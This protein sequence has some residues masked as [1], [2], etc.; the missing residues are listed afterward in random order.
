MPLQK[1]EL[2]PGVNREGTTL[3]NE[4]GWFDCDKIRFR[5]GY[6]QKLGGWQLLS[7][8]T[9]R[10]LVTNLWNY[11]TLKGYDLLSVA[12]NSKYYIE[13]GG[14][15]YDIT[16]IRL[17]TTAGSVTFFATSGSNI[18]TV[19][20]A[21][22]GAGSGDFVT[23]FGAV[24]LGGNVTAVILNQEY[25][26]IYYSSNSFGIV[27]LVNANSLDTG[28]GGSSAYGEFQLNIGITDVL[29][30]VGW[31]AGLWGGYVNNQPAT[32]LNGAINSSVTTITLTSV[33][34]FP[35][36]AQQ[37]VLI[38]E[39][40]IQYAAIAGNTLTGCVRGYSG[41]HAVS[42]LTLAPVTLA[43]AFTSWGTSIG[44]SG[45]LLRLWSGDNFGEFL[46]FNPRNYGLY[47]WI[48]EYDNQG[49]ISTFFTRGVLL[50]PTSGPSNT[51]NGGITS[52][53]VTVVVVSTTG[54]PTVGMIRVDQELISYTAISSVAF[55]GCTR[56][57]GGTAPVPHIS[58][59]TVYGT[60]AYQTDVDCPSIMTQM[61][62]SDQSRFV[63]AFGCNDYGSTDQNRMLVR[64]S[65]QEDYKTW[66]PSIVNQA[67]SYLLSNGS[68][69]VS[70]IQ[71]RQE[72]FILTD[73]AAYS[74]QYIGPPYVWSFNILSYNISIIGPNTVSTAS[75]IVYWMGKDK[76][77]CYTGRVETLPCTLRQYVYGNINM[78]Q[79]NKFFSGTNEGYS[80]VWWFYCSADSDTIDKYV[81]YN[82]LD[83][84]WYYGTMARTA[85]L[86]SGVRDF[87]MA[88]TYAHTMVYHEVGT[89][90]QE[91]EGVTTA[92]DS[93]IQSSDF[94]IGDGHNYG[95]VWRII[96]DLTFDGS[97]TAAP[98]KPEVTLSVR[99]R[100][101]PGAPYGTADVPIV[102]S[103][104][105]YAEQKNYTV[106]EFTQIVYTRLRG[107]QMA[108]K[109]GSNTLGTQWQLGAPR[110]DIRP[111]GRR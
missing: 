12:T 33:V 61:L 110:I 29:S 92:I 98:D 40:L 93:Y 108:L 1:L 59:T 4:G 21:N 84:V 79:A 19:N 82:Y 24:S 42:H 23:F 52:I 95:F 70:A 22:H 39:E 107:R 54:F 80:E 67:G 85:W 66:T 75:D 3:S 7:P 38:G 63:I 97:T 44:T 69:I 100:Q 14:N 60:G 62:I 77:Y 57:I 68:G 65:D 48:P 31:G 47:M 74:M 91:V 86:D 81:I 10:G 27:L 17:T 43:N 96:P 41:T 25:E 99:P 76:F 49:V 53:D 50:S 72:I 35:S 9:Y 58:G 2:R 102:Q 64:W 5:S 90:S 106:Q 55:L 51:L 6:P 11:V 37:I 13:S 26:I 105:S 101:N 45:T 103:A 104:Q 34:G 36:A 109:I 20:C 88:A 16:P 83:K 46:M 71:T 56:G 15:Y 111:D 89:N 18:V 28:H 87:P 8:R 30:T 78:G 94:D 32:V 73:S